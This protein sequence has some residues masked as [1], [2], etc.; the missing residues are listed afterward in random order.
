[1]WLYTGAKDKTRTNSAD[2]TEKELQDEVRHLTHFS[3]ED[4]ISLTS[5][6][7]PYD[8]RHLPAEV[9]LVTRLSCTRFIIRT[10]N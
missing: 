9:I 6:Q 8:V 3:Q 7:T 1:M 10:R 5:I 4:F 2:L